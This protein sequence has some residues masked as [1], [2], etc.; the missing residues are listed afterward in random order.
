MLVADGRQKQVDRVGQ[1]SAA[2]RCDCFDHQIHRAASTTSVRLH[3]SIFVKKL[4]GW[5]DVQ[6]RREC[7]AL[8]LFHSD[9]QMVC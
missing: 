5:F 2:E 3:E 6:E 9:P 8:W 1:N 7:L 4:F